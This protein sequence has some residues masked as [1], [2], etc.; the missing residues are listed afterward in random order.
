MKDKVL[1][2]ERRIKAIRDRGNK[3][4]E[5]YG[6]TMASKYNVPVSKQLVNIINSSDMQRLLAIGKEMDSI[7]ENYERLKRKVEAAGLLKTTENNNNDDYYFPLGR[8]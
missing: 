5:E 8:D 7:V 2:Y 6:I 1:S 4:V 3:F